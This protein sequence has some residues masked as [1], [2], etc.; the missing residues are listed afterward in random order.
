MS[1]HGIYAQENFGYM[2]QE[3]KIFI[4]AL[5][6][7]VKYYKPPKCRVN[8]AEKKYFLSIHTIENYTVV[9]SINNS[10]KFQHGFIFIY[11]FISTFRFREYMCRFVT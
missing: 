9:K 6:V 1:T 5:L 7:K 2:Y 4:A 8:G 11:L 3:T 10:Y